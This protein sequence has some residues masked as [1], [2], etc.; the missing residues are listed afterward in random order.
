MTGSVRRVTHQGEVCTWAVLGLSLKEAEKLSAPLAQHMA[1]YS[2]VCTVG[3]ALFFFPDRILICSLG[4]PQITVRFSCPCLLRAGIISMSHHIW[5]Q[6]PGLI[7]SISASSDTE[8]GF[9]KDA[10]KCLPPDALNQP[11]VKVTVLTN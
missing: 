5:S 2:M 1:P 9:T 8:M 7:S 6:L 3:I 4:W 11:Q 10:V